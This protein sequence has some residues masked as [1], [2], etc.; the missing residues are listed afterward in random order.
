MAGSENRHKESGLIM[1]PDFLMSIS[2]REFNQLREFIYSHTGISLSD[3]KRMLLCSRLSKRLRY[4]GFKKYK[5]YFNY[6]TEQDSSGEE[7]VEM[8]NAMTTNKTDFFRETHHFQ[9]IKDKVIPAVKQRAKNTGSRHLR[10]WSAGSSTGEEAYTLAMTLLDCFPE[11]Y[12]WNMKILAT[13]IDTRVLEKAAAGIYSLEQ[14]KKVPF[15]YWDRFFKKM[16]DSQQ[17]VVKSELK[18]MIHFLWLNLLTNPWPMHGLF[19]VIFC[20]NVIIYFNSE[21]QH[22]L[23]DRMAQILKP[24]GYLM[25]GHSESLHGI[26]DGFRHV[27]HSIYQL[28]TGDFCEDSR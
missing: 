21:T 10:F 28:K 18:A 19:D 11:L 13:D 22:Q 23:I 20:R 4:F 14:S 17:V 1:S 9:F 26:H 3:H 6:L 25:L 12:N 5:E 2:D 7:L 16:P 27:G 24:G 8:I 15:I